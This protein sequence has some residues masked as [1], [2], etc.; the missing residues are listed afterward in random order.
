MHDYMGQ[1]GVPLDA[2]KLN[3]WDTEGKPRQPSHETRKRT[4]DSQA[5]QT[6]VKHQ[7]DRSVKHLPGHDTRP[8]PSR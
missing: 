7:V 3:N 1:H 8:Q 2:W 4:R 5:E 6:P